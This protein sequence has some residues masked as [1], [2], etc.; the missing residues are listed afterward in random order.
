MGGHYRDDVSVRVERPDD[1][2]LFACHLVG[3]ALA[4]ARTAQKFI[5]KKRERV[6]MKNKS[7]SGKNP[8]LGAQEA[9][10]SPATLFAIICRFR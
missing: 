7:L 2:S 3:N 1:S 4:R 5:A 8:A 6:A 10:V 9:R